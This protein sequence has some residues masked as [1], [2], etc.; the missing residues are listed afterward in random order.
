[1]FDAT[2]LKIIRFCAIECS[3]QQSGEV[4]VSWMLD[5]WCYA[6]NSIWAQPTID[7]VI[8]LGS[9]VEPVKNAD[10]FRTVG[11]RVGYDV[12]MDWAEVPRQMSLLMENQG[13]LTPDE[14]FYQYEVI[15]GFR[16]GNGRTGAILFNWLSGTLND[17][18]WP[19]NFWGDPRRTPG[20][21]A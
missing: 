3:L 6:Q 11:V 12:K 14:F 1:M 16:D 5:A 4:S 18:N 10:G 15:H 7:D 20:H 8:N 9:I 19:P 2:T 17:P 21:G 13:S